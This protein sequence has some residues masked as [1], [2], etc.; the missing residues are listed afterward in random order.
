MSRNQ[1]LADALRF[2]QGNNLIFAVT[3]LLG[4]FAR[5]MVLPY[6]S[7]YILALGGDT[8][9]IGLVNSIGPLAGLIM[10]PIGGYI[11][12]HASRVKL[13]ALGS[14]FSAAVVVM[15]I[16]APSWEVLAVAA[17]L[18]GFGVFPFPARSALIAD[19]LPPGDRG[20][21]IA[22]QNAISWGMAVFAPYIGG[23]VVDT[24]GPKTGLRGLYWVMMSFYVLSAIIQIRFL[25]ET[26]VR[27][28]SETRLAVSDLRG[29]LQDAYGDI[30]SMLRQLPRSLKAL[31][32]VIVLSFVATAIAAP[33][34]VLYA[35]EHIGLSSSAWGLVLLVEMILKSVMFVPAGVLVDRWGRT[36]SLVAA[37]LISLV[38]IP[39]FVFA[40]GIT[41]VLMIRLAIAVAFAIGI[42]AC[43]ALMADIVP[44][45]IRGRVMGALGQGG[46][47]I[48]T[49]GG[50]GG[51]GV[52]YV[53]IVPLMIASLAGGYLYTW[54]PASPW[55]V[56][57]IATGI[58]VILIVLF[59][60]DPGQAEV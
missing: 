40:S 31:A 21:G 45:D 49:A 14:C 29:V 12:D 17:L 28:G 6:V 34:W 58:A 10:F 50:V 15:Y 44:R 41:A 46:I 37:L 23:V 47:L 3:D 59:I 7:L 5:G 18:Q 25:K 20:R 43:S 51:P 26:T 30:P 39:L 4:N 32:G 22:V 27:P 11:T 53:T 42:P 9:Q 55:F 57:T 35:V 36:T 8:T 13:V 24:Y 16:L 19:S 33:F 54:N 38:S 1:R 52:G 2:V 60:R 56:A 48:G